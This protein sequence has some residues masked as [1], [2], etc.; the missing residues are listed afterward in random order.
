MK[1]IT[2]NSNV[3]EWTEGMT[4]TGILKV[5]NYTFKLLVIHVNGKIIK[6]EDWPLTLVPENAEV[7]VIHLMSGG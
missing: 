2:V 4:V 5:M 1:T 6:K 7:K 3:I